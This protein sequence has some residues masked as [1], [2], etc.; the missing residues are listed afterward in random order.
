MVKIKLKDITSKRPDVVSGLK[1]HSPEISVVKIYEYGPVRFIHSFQDDTQMLSI[2]RSKD[3]VSQADWILGIQQIMKLELVEAIISVRPSGV[4]IIR[5][6]PDH[7]PR[8]AH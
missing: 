3:K 8:T 6:K 5:E 4:V 7:L 1:A 2:S